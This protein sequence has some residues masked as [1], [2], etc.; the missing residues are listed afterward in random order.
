MERFGNFSNEN[1]LG[2]VNKSRNTNTKKATNNCMDVYL[3]WAGA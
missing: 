1:I 3:R 2:L